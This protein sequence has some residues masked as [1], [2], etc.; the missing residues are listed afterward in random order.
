MMSG[1]IFMIVFI[2]Y[3]CHR[4]VNKQRPH[5]Y[6]NYWRPEPEIP[7]L[8]IFTMDSHAMVN[9]RIIYQFI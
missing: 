8:E 3:C 6:T 9:N 5:E 4:N 7:N 1:L 2:C